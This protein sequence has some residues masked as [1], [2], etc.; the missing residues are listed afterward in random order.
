MSM[1]LSNVAVDVRL[2]YITLLAVD[3]LACLWRKTRVVV[4]PMVARQPGDA[5]HL[6]LPSAGVV[7]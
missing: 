5:P 3:A 1:F 4:D 7:T 6:D 2:G